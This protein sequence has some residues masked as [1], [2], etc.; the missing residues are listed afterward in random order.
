MQAAAVDVG[1]P[2]G[3]HADRTP[4]MGR[5]RRG[6]AWGGVR[7]PPS[8]SVLA[9]ARAPPSASVLAAAPRVTA[10]MCPRVPVIATSPSRSVRRTG[11][12]SRPSAASSDG[13]GWP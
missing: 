3:S 9:A 10:T 13:A 8:A 6:A 1:P 5:C 7:A 11:I 12:E 2:P 4:F